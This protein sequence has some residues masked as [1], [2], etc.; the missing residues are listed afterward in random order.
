MKFSPED[1]GAIKDY[2]RLRRL[3][4]D[5]LRDVRKVFLDYNMDEDGIIYE[6]GDYFFLRFFSGDQEVSPG[7]KLSERHIVVPVCW[8]KEDKRCLKLGFRPDPEFKGY[9]VKYMDIGPDFLSLEF[10]EQK[11]RVLDFFRE[12]ASELAVAGIIQQPGY[13]IA[14]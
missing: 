6:Q 1:A 9:M 12:V 13:Y 10:E 7:I 11:K 8:V 2:R 14:G 3:V 4:K 5:V